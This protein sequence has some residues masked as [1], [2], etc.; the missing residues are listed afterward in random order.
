MDSDKEKTFIGK[1]LRVFVSYATEDR[2]LA[3]ALK[4]ELEDFG[5]DVFLAH[6]DITP[7]TDWQATILATLKQCDIFL[8]LLTNNF[9]KSPWTD[10]ETGVAI[11]TQKF[12]IPLKV[13]IDPYGFI[14]KY[15]AFKFGYET[16]E[17]D[18]GNYYYD[19]KDSC[20]NIVNLILRHKTLRENLKDCL[21]RV[22]ANCVTFA[23][24]KEKAE[25]LGNFESFTEEQISE[26]IKVSVNNNQ[27][28]DSWGARPILQ[29]LISNYDKLIDDKKKEELLKLIK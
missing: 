8:P 3:V 16:R 24:A 5:I 4:R 20:R 19:C 17:L 6:E 2:F 21:I 14:G 22:F 15:Q 26:I 9:S 27:I 7:T 11:A 10:Q 25:L 23:E 28:H 18:N 29:K 12:I 1:S 13:N